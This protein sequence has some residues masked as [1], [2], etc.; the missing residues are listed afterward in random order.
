MHPSTNKMRVYCKMFFVGT[1]VRLT[2]SR[3]QSTS[4]QK[5]HYS[6]ENDSAHC[7]FDMIDGLTIYV[8]LLRFE[9]DTLSSW[10]FDPSRFATTDRFSSGQVVR[11][12][13]Y[14]SSMFPLFLIQFRLLFPQTLCCR[15]QNFVLNF[16]VLLKIV[17]DNFIFTLLRF[18]IVDYLN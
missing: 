9:E 12:P 11:L 1:N 17:H 3:R 14:D 8:F 13:C 7:S 10:A 5:I 16:V 18:N 4:S 6:S 15:A 2:T